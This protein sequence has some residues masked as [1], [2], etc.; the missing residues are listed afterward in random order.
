MKIGAGMFA[1]HPELTFLQ[2]FLA[3]SERGLSLFRYACFNNNEE[4]KGLRSFLAQV[5]Q[6]PENKATVSRLYEA[7]LGMAKETPRPISQLDYVIKYLL[8]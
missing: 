3:A 5:R 7:L 8:S 1:K 6:L 4:A 2:Q